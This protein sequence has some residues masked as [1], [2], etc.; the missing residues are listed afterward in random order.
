MVNKKIKVINKLSPFFKCPGG[1]RRLLI[2]LHKHL[3]K[4]FFTNNYT[5]IEPFVGGGA[6][7]LSIL[8][9]SSKQKIIINDSNLHIANLWKS[10][11]HHPKEMMQHYDF[12]I[13]FY[14]EDVNRYLTIR[15][16]LPLLNKNF[17]TLEAEKLLNSATEFLYLNKNTYNGLIRFNKSG[18]FNAPPGNSLNPNLLNSSEP[19]DKISLIS[20]ATLICNIPPSFGSSLLRII[21]RSSPLNFTFMS[22][23]F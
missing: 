11:K 14:K 20:L 5:Y 4:D 18:K 8:E 12:L 16:N 17:C 3:P 23:C 2:E 1:K 6:L 13:K 15:D 10:I 21:I 7:A 9:Q 22:V 19:I